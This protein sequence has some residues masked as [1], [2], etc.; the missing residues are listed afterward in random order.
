MGK[1]FTIFFQTDENS[2]CLLSKIYCCKD[3]R[4]Q[5][6]F[7]LFHLKRKKYYLSHSYSYSHSLSLSLFLSLSLSLSLTRSHSLTLTQ[8]MSELVTLYFLFCFVFFIHDLPRHAI[9]LIRKNVR[10]QQQQQ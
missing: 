3:K 10:D 4:S 9:T 2:F 6:T 8:R 7:S 1:N 5:P